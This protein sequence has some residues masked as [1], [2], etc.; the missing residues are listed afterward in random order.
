MDTFDEGHWDLLLG[1]IHSKRCT[2]FIGAGASADFLP[3]GSEVAETWAKETG[4]PLADSWDLARVAQYMAVTRDRMWPKEKLCRWFR[5]QP[6]PRFSAPH[7]PHRV[8]AALELPVYITTN[9]DGF[10]AQALRERGKNPKESVCMWHGSLKKLVPPELKPDLD[11]VPTPDSPLV[12]HLHGHVD[13]PASLVLTSDDYLDFIITLA[14]DRKILPPYIRQLFT[15][16]SLLFVGYR[17]EDL[18]FRVI[19]R[20]L[21]TYLDFSLDLELSHVSVQSMRG[22]EIPDEER[23]KRVRN[24]LTRYFQTNRITVFWGPTAEFTGELVSRWE[25]HSNGG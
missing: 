14:R 7:Q 13:V 20:S 17:L 4:Y 12:F 5:E 2:P 3:V 10:M 16:T 21:V 18:N 19:F 1:R 25:A 6:P 15:E 11:F 8:L 22:R 24:Y 23:E 9:Y